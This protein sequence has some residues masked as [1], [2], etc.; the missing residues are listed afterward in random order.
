[1]NSGGDLTHRTDED[2]LEAAMMTDAGARRVAAE[3]LTRFERV[4]EGTPAR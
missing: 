3:V 4:R 1:M 2:A